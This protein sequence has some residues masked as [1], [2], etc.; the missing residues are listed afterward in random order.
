[1]AQASGKPIVQIAELEIDPSQ[2]ES[3]KALLI[4]EIEASVRIEPGVLALNAVSVKGSPSQIRILEVYANREAYE[5]HLLAAHFLKY[6]AQTA[7]MVRSLNL[8]QTDPI[9][10]CSKHQQA[11]A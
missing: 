8:V 11:G 6:K 3:Y 10:L 7:D 2:L 1:M 9:L 5:A 4:E